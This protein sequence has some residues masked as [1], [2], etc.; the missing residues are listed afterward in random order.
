MLRKFDVTMKMTEN[1]VHKNV[2]NEHYITLYG[3]IYNFIFISPCRL[4]DLLTSDDPYLR[5]RVPMIY[6]TIANQAAGR[7]AILKNLTIIA[8]LSKGLDDHL[9][10][11]RLQ[12]AQAVEALAR[13]R[14]G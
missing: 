10:A 3:Y 1:N 6:A 4:T 9:A 14:C 7:K 12:I 8:N 5:E 11:V 13:D 2:I